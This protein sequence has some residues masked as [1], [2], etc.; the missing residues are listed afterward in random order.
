MSHQIAPGAN[1]EW[2]KFKLYMQ[3]A[4]L[5]NFDNAGENDEV[6]RQ[7]M[8]C[9]LVQFAFKQGYSTAYAE[10]TQEEHDQPTHKITRNVETRKLRPFEVR[11]TD[12][13]LLVEILAKH[14]G[15]VPVSE[16]IVCMHQAG[17]DHWNNNNATSFI[18]TAIRDGI[19]IQRG[20]KR[21]YYQLTER[22]LVNA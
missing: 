1:A 21:G 20:I 16:I 3:D 6:E 17:H 9:A 10:L 22:G 14:G 19:G 8:T 15:N 7:K 4:G 2:E 5:V 13:A 12:N 18:N 11:K